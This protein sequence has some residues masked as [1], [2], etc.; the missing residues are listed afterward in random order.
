M[1][2]VSLISEQPS[3]FQNSVK[4]LKNSVTPQNEGLILRKWQKDSLYGWIG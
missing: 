4:M 3:Y 1:A 2:S